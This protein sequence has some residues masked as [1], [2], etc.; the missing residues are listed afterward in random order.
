MSYLEN[1]KQAAGKVQPKVE[2]VAS[3]STGKHIF[4]EVE[5]LMKTAA[6]E[7]LESTIISPKVISA[8]GLTPYLNSSKEEKAEEKAE[9][10]QEAKEDAKEEAQEEASDEDEEE[11]LEEIKEAQ[12][13]FAKALAL[14]K[15]AQA[16][17]DE[18]Q[19]IKVAALNI[20]IR[21]NQIDPDTAEKVA[22]MSYDELLEK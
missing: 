5:S 10:K 13:Y 11:K 20:L 14:E 12:E 8:L 6:E 2:K 7:D 1:I 15:E 4:K 18:A 22:S 19:I 21:N 9:E 3:V 16:A 17:Y